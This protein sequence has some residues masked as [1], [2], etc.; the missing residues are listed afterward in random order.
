VHSATVFT[1][2]RWVSV[3]NNPAP[4]TGLEAKFSYR[5]TAAMALSG[6][7]TARIENFNDDI[8]ADPALVALRD[9]ITVHENPEL[10]EMQARV[11]LTLTDGTTQA[12]FHDLNA[13]ITTEIRTGRLIQKARAVVGRALADELWQAV[14]SGDRANLT[15]LLQRP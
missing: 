4:Q 15:A 12:L 13:P 11:R 14:Q 2:P 3:C 7:S 1:H 5:F 6:V 9:R 10:S 8:I